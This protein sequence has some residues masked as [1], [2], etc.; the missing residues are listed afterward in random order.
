MNIFRELKN[1]INESIVYGLSSVISSLVQFF[2]LPLYTRVFTTEDYGRISLVLATMAFLNIFSG[3]ALDN[4]A[5]RWFFATS[6]KTDQKITI[7][8]WAWCQWLITL[9]IGLSLISLSDFIAS[10]LIKDSIITLC[11]QISGLTLFVSSNQKIITNWLRFQR[12]AWSTTL[13]A[14]FSN[15]LTIS[16]SVLFVL[17]IGL[18]VIGVFIA[19]VI[20]S[21]CMFVITIAIMKDWLSFKYFS[22]SRLKEMLVYGFPLIP[23]SLAFWVVNLSDRYVIR[24]YD[25]SS[26]VG[27]YQVGFMISASITLITSSFQQAWGPFA[28]SFHQRKDAPK[29]YATVFYIYC[30][31][32]SFLALILCVLAPYIL[33]ILAPPE[34]KDAISVVPFLVFSNIFIG[35]TYIAAIGLSI[36]K[37]TVPIGLGITFAAIANIVLNI[38]LVPYL[39]KIGAALATL[40]SQSITPIYMF[41]KAQQLYPIPYPFKKGTLCYL[42]SGILIYGIYFNWLV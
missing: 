41:T 5:A 18:G 29:L 19:E 32:T 16:L 34:Y 20:A 35:L 42:V 28:M 2:L 10:Y 7:A 22:W 26:E 13:F 9:L 27:L 40:I 33:S 38:I 39:G 31:V 37:T 21:F 8:S 24:L 1:L 4:S 15:I 6:D 12:R 36:A 25:N 3:L 30:I 17:Y 23:A 14:I 11:L